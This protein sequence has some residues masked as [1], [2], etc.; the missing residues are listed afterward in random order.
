MDYKEKYFK[1]KIKYFELKK[2]L[3]GNI[4][5][6]QNEIINILKPYK[7][8]SDLGTYKGRRN[9]EDIKLGISKTNT[10]KRLKLLTKERDF[11][12]SNDLPETI[13]TVESYF[14]YINL[15]KLYS[16]PTIE[17]PTPEQ[18]PQFTIPPE[19]LQK[20]FELTKENLEE[21]KRIAIEN[22]RSINLKKMDIIFPRLH[23]CNYD[24]V[25][26]IPDNVL[27]V[28][29]SI[30]GLSV[31]W[32]SNKNN[33]VFDPKN[34]NLLLDPITN[35]E[36]I[37]KISGLNLN[38]HYSN[39]N[40]RRGT[41]AQSKIG[42]INFGS[43]L[44]Y[45]SMNK[46][47]EIY[48]KYRCT[49]ILTLK[50]INEVI[51]NTNNTNI[52]N[53]QGESKKLSKKNKISE[54]ELLNMF[55]YSKAP[56]KGKGKGKGKG[57]SGVL[58]IFRRT[59][60]VPKFNKEFKTKYNNITLENLMDFKSPKLNHVGK[61]ID[62][63]T[64][65]IIIFIL[66][67]RGSCDSVKDLKPT[68]QLSMD[69][70]MDLLKSSDESVDEKELR[71]R[72]EKKIEKLILKLFIKNLKKDKHFDREKLIIEE[73]V[74]DMGKKFIIVYTY[75]KLKYLKLKY[76]EI[77]KAE[78]KKIISFSE[79]LK[80]ILSLIRELLEEDTSITY[81]DITELEDKENPNKI[82]SFDD[83]D[84]EYKTIIN[85]EIEDDYYKTKKSEIDAELK[86]LN[87]I[88]IHNYFVNPT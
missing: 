52:I 88:N 1:Y 51:K 64:N 74:S 9:Q 34:H 68:R 20:D 70:R 15:P 4:E 55:E 23:S 43:P 81:S 58:S 25:L 31:V 30:C 2:Q 80:Y 26:T 44:L 83:L 54:E 6:I 67:C 19:V 37:E 27:V 57:S 50:K 16:E 76:A 86:N 41:S 85:E 33:L 29:T 72:E 61:I 18:I 28:T 12:K 73:Y 71:K 75:L 82:I 60:S 46:E 45:S 38:F 24:K 14:E 35:K 79:R 87:L 13:N 77:T 10:E 62:D 48:T 59:K 5:A 49:G 65:N 84:T 78:M 22:L 7:K 21:N 11:I 36:K 56:F 39:F 69:A 17:T 63:K 40:G 47:Q 42:N 53:C 8:I 66:T 3:G 32:N